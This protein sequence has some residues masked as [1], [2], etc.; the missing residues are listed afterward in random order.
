[1][2]SRNPNLVEAVVR[3]LA[4]VMAEAV[5]VAEAATNTDHRVVTI[6]L[7]QR[8]K[9]SVVT[10]AHHILLGNVL[11][12]DKT[13]TCGKS[14]HYSRYCRSRQRS[15]TPGR[16]S[17]QEM[18]EMELDEEYE[19]DTI[20]IIHKVKFSSSCHKEHDS[21]KNNVM[22]DEIADVPKHNLRMLLDLY[23]QTRS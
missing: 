13:Y 20:Q 7:H 23:A 4:G 18:H 22:F 17:H 19:Y 11:H 14:G 9:A 15:S 16:R 1:M 3:E 10:V 8:G 21:N 5:E 6:T 12:M 2:P